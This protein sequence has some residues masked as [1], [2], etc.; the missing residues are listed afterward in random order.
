MQT[1][2]TLFPTAPPTD[3]APPSG[4]DHNLILLVEDHDP[5]RES[6]KDLLEQWGY[7]VMAAASAEEALAMAGPPIDLVISDL[8]LPNQ[9]GFDLMRVLKATYGYRG[10]ALSGLGTDADIARARA[11]GFERH[12]SKPVTAEELDDALAWMLGR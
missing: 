11:A 8:G 12:L 1:L 6:L 3:P 7:R 2:P 9:N 4:A 5:T 10:I